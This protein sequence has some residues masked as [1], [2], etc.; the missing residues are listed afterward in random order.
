MKVING[1]ALPKKRND[2][3]KSILDPYVRISIHGIPKDTV[4]QKTDV[5]KNNGKFVLISY[6][7]FSIDQVKTE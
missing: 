2:A 7:M 4:E 5:I 3:A 1:F 6:Q